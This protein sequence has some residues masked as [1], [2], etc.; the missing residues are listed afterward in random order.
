MKPAHYALLSL[1]AFAA[2]AV[3]GLTEPTLVTGGYDSDGVT[4]NAAWS[5]GVAKNATESGESDCAIIRSGRFTWSITL[6]FLSAGLLGCAII[7]A[8]HEREPVHAGPYAPFMPQPGPGGPQSGPQTPS[9]ADPPSDPQQ[10]QGPPPI[11]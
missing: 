4:C 10:P 5:G 11:Q 3:I 6:V 1:M 2:A 8:R 9:P 7:S